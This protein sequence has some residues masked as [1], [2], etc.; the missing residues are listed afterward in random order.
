[1]MRMFSAQMRGSSGVWKTGKTPRACQHTTSWD[2][3][4]QSLSVVW[5]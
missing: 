5:W 2:A 4:S 1:M 3:Q